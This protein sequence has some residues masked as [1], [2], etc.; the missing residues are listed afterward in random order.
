MTVENYLAEAGA[1]GTLAGVLA[2]FA[3]SAVIQ[4]LTTNS[5]SKVAT[6]TIVAFAASTVMFLYS[7]IVFVLTFA[8]TAEQNQVITELDSLGSIAVL[9]MLGAVFVFLA[10]IGLTGWIRSR[11]TGIITSSF[12]VFTMCITSFAIVSVMSV[13]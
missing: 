1:L 9:V 7:L 3:I 10:G 13:F 12:A 5:E 6:A 4:L 8:A 11:N 2:G